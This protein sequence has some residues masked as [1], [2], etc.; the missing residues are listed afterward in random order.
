VDSANKESAR[1]VANAQKE[2]D[3]IVAKARTQ[4]DMIRSDAQAEAGKMQAN[5]EASIKQAARDAV[6]KLKE[7]ITGM[8]DGVLRR[9][10]AAAFDVGFMKNLIVKVVETM[11]QG[12][13]V[14]VLAGNVDIEELRKQVLAGLKGDLKNTVTIKL[15]KRIDY[16]FR[17]GMKGQ[18]VYYDFTDES[19]LESLKLFLN[20]KLKELL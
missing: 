19:I 13:P 12:K 1:I 2:A 8:F 5:A 4:A 16:G 10:S 3:A 20:Q 14:E 9:E 17:I 15:D 6:L 18:E 7:Q 11:A